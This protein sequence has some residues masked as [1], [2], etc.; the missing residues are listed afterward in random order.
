MESYESA[1]LSFRE[2][3]PELIRQAD[4]VPEKILSTPITIIGAGA[5]GSFTAL[6]LAK[7]G[8]LDITVWDFDNVEVHNLNSQF[9]RF[10]DIGMPKVFAL[11]NLIKDFTNQ[12]IK[13]ECGEYTDERFDGVVI[14]AVD[15]MVARKNIWQAHRMKSIATEFIIDPRMGGEDVNMYVMRPYNMVDIEAYETTLHSEEDSAEERCTAK[16]TM[17]TALLLSGSVAKA[18]RDCLTGNY[19][20]TLQ[21]SIKH[22]DMIA[23]NSA[24]PLNPFVYTNTVVSEPAQPI[25]RSGLTVNDWTNNHI[26]EW[27]RAYLSPEQRTIPL[28]QDSSGIEEPAPMS[29]LSNRLDYVPMSRYS[30]PTPRLGGPLSETD[31]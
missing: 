24:P 10:K 12:E 5:I 27:R 4:L 14:S 1:P 26:E 29:M 7:M 31:F 22:D 25:R 11:R 13:V 17:F 3:R 30:L 19:C 8:F 23:T 18:V 2:N 15:S 9:F 6:T 20:R 21:W 28:P 16:A